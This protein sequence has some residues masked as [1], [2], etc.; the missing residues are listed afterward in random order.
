MTEIELFRSSTW[1]W[2][3]AAI[4]GA[5]AGLVGVLLQFRLESGLVSEAWISRLK[6]LGRA[7][8]VVGIIVPAVAQY[9]TSE[10]S[11][12]AV[13]VLDERVKAQMQIQP[14][15]RENLILEGKNLELENRQRE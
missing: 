6:R 10:I 4:I 14:L 5:L 13:A 9:K 8:I 7:L 11:S 15:K 2:D 3:C 12:L 1:P